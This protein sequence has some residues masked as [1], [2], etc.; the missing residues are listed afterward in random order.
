MR[1]SAGA[2]LVPPRA[3]RSTRSSKKARRLVERLKREIDDDPDA[4]NRRIEAAQK[5]A[6]RE[7]QARVEAALAKQAE[8]AAE[9]ERR[10]KTN[11]NASRPRSRRSRA[12]RRPTPRRAS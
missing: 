11:K 6:A 3:R 8:L 7:R 1:A 12:P 10:R 4:S 2:S 9:R 5:R